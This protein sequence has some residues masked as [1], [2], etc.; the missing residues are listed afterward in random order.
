MPSVG[1]FVRELNEIE[2]VSGLTDTDYLL[3]DNNFF[4]KRVSLETLSGYLG[5]TAGGFDDSH[6]LANDSYL[7]GFIDQNSLN[8]DY[9]SGVSNYLSASIDNISFDDSQLLANDFYLSG[10]IDQNSL[11]INYLS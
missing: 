8:I 10:A 7:S 4:N 9:L 1:K 2:T 11:N 5:V 3:I 6:L